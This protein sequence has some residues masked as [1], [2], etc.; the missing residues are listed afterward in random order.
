LQQH[1]PTVF[2]SAWQFF[3][4]A[5]FLTWRATGSLARSVCTVTCKWT[6]LAHESRWDP[7]Y[8]Q[9]IGLGVLADEGFAR[10]GTDIVTPGTPLAQGLTAQAAADLG[11]RAG[12]AVG[13]GLIDAHA[14]GVGTV[15][16][17]GDPTACL[18]YVFGTSS[19][20][21]TTTRDAA[22]VP[23]VWGPYYNVMVSDAWLV[24]GGQS[25][26]GAAIDHLLT[27]HPAHAEATA[28]AQAAG[29]A[30]PL[31]LANRAKGKV[32]RLSDVVLLAGR[33]HVVPEF[34]GNRAPFANPH[35]RAIIAGMGMDKDIDS[36]IALYI[37][38][39][40]GIGYGLRQIIM[41]Q[42]AH[43]APIARIV[44]SGGAGQD[45]LIRQLIADATGLPVVATQCDEPVLLGSAIL[46]AIAAGLQPSMTAAMA[47][48]S[49]VKTTYMP[50]KVDGP[51]GTH[52]HDAR[53]RAFE[54]LQQTA[55]T[56]G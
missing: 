50:H 37:A 25:A 54:A 32:A 28:A 15:G 43:G 35:A 52:W 4:L 16:A 12:T 13:A 27:L 33:L 53:F 44:I 56:L 14:G 36:L 21:M 40:C 7:S 41:A 11:L 30:L 17:D 42:N 5:D 3:D 24:E 34:L 23:G 46:G 26:A 9:A 2:D 39:L 22:F 31:W 10:I 20:T 18:G 45:D 55:L 48:M 19:C 49:R 38:G 51:D 29:Q 1:R 6:Y 8:F 47:A